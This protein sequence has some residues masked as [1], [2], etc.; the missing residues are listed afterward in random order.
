MIWNDTCGMLRNS[1]NSTERKPRKAYVKTESVALRSSLRALTRNLSWRQWNLRNLRVEDVP[2]I[3]HF[4]YKKCICFR[5][6]F[7]FIAR[8]LTAI[9]SYCTVRHPM[10]E[11][12]DIIFPQV[13]ACW[14]VLIEASMKLSLKQLE[15]TVPE[16]N[17]IPDDTSLLPAETLSGCSG[18]RGRNVGG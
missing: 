4:C 16:N 12:H 7:D 9:A 17:Q 5:S 8:H 14:L 13:R 2:E 10:R 15:D 1:G 3:L 18:F 11:D 6:D